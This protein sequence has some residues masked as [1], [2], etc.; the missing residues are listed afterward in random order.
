MLISYQNGIN[1]RMRQPE[2]DIESKGRA[3]ARPFFKTPAKDKS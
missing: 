1:R 3:T 2:L